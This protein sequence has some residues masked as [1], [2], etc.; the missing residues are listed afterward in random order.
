VWISVSR[1]SEFEGR[2]VTYRT[3][4][5]ERKVEKEQ[6]EISW[7]KAVGEH[8]DETA[9]EDNRDGIHPEPI[10]HPESIRC[11]RMQVRVT[12]H[13]EVWRRYQ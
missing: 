9:H 11:R 2:P 3:V 4:H 1:M 7:S 10:S 12:H 5:G 13:E 8:E 6:T